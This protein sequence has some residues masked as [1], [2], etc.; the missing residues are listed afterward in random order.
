LA[1]D[2]GLVIETE[3]RLGLHGHWQ[4]GNFPAGLTSLTLSTS[5]ILLSGIALSNPLAIGV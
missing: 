5:G 3:D 2:F 1:A 4:S